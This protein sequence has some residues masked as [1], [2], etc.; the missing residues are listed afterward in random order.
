MYSYPVEINGTTYRSGSQC[1]KALGIK[2]ENVLRYSRRHN[3]TIKHAILVYLKGGS[4]S[5]TIDGV[6]Y[7][8]KKECCDKL[9]I[10]YSQVIRYKNYHNI[11]W[12]ET[13]KIY[14]DK[15]GT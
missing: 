1:C 2:Y 11:T 9:G 6:L 7:E 5:I 10:S 12:E 3:V 14:K 4:R 13:I 15:K 8:S